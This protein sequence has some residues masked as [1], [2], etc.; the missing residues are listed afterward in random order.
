MRRSRNKIKSN[1]S[2]ENQADDAL[3]TLAPTSVYSS[4]S[5]SQP[6]MSKFCP[7]TL[8]S[9]LS[10]AKELSQA[11]NPLQS[12]SKNQQPAISHTLQSFSEHDY[13]YTFR[14]ES[15][16]SLAYEKQLRQSLYEYTISSIPSKHLYEN[17][18]NVIR[19]ANE[20]RLTLQKAMQYAMNSLELARETKNAMSR[21]E[22]SIQNL[23]DVADA[24]FEL[25]EID[26]NA[27]DLVMKSMCYDKLKNNYYKKMS[28]VENSQGG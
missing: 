7:K 6:D 11:N 12:Q 10:C 23:E 2:P 26:K 8:H 1:E 4:S 28:Q 22:E 25:L 19:L 24:M 20:D 15:E 21:V 3:E 27:S 17:T 5:R 16:S 13:D 9:L 18:D 14:N